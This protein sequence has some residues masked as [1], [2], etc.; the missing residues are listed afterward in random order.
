MLCQFER[1]LFP[2]DA[3]AAASGCYMVAIYKPCEIVRDSDGDA[4]RQIKAVGYFLPT[5]PNLRFEM[6][7]HWIRNAKHGIQYEMESYEEVIIPTKEGIIAYLSS[8]QIRGIGKKT[9]EKIYATFGDLALEVLDK[10]P[11]KLLSVPG[12]STARLEKITTSYLL[13]RGARDVVTFLTPYGITP[14]RAVK[15]YREYG[16]D[17]MDIVKNHP[18]RLCELAGIGFKTADKI[19]VKM[20][21]DSLSTE[22]VD[23]GLLYTLTEAESNGNLCM[24]KHAF[25]KSGLKLLDT[26]GLTED[27]LTARASRLVYS[28]EL[29]AYRGMVYRERAAKQEMKIAL[30]VNDRLSSKQAGCYPDL[31][32]MLEQE[33]RSLGVRLAFEQRDAIKTALTSPISIITGGPGT[34]KT[35][36]QRA[37]LDLYLKANPGNRICCCAPTG[38]A[39]RRMEQAT[40]R[41]AS[42]VHK[43]LGL[44]ATSEGYSGGGE[45]IDADLILVDESSM[46]DA[47]LAVKLFE[48]IPKESQL[49]L[50]GDVDQLPSVGPGAVLSELISSGRIP[51]VKLDRV[52]RQNAGSRIATNAKLIRHG[53]L[54]LEY[55]PSEFVFVDSPNIAESAEK[56]L[57]L[58]M[59]EVKTYGSDA[60]ALLSP[61]RQNTATGVNS[62]NMTIQERVNPPAP[63]KAEIA[64]GR[65]TFRVGDKVMQIRNYEDVNNGDIGYITDIHLHGSESTAIVDFRDGRIKEYDSSE[66]EMLDLGYAC[67]VHKSQGSEYRSVLINLQCAHYNM[68]TRPL[69]YTAI[70]RGRDK[71]TIV[72]ERRALCMAIRRK[73][74]EKRGTCL[75]ARLQ[76]MKA[77]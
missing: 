28:G 31:E 71:V 76:E 63:G 4:V 49:I 44:L 62:L 3:K 73:D 2:K 7:G 21:I 48:A 32:P 66:L 68:L 54:A 27:M 70:T 25:I 20:G 39:A 61:Y 1:L 35:M 9:A 47:Y 17:A 11:E 56:L 55:N 24:E 37:I 26:P 60:V 72:G 10:E 45:P 30:L 65:R 67:T 42:T 14:Y 22:R 46:L 74:T 38:I 69:V 19:A 16:Q 23:E 6:Q 50:I 57:D 33:E 13:N 15:L 12:I 41:P 75:A 5:A 52:F 29:V 36:I 58:Y 59:E 40:G 64:V 51:V 43:A 34:G 8:G 77:E 53:V 18:Y